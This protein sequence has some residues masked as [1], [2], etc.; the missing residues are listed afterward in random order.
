MRLL[1]LGKPG[2]GKGTQA[3][4]IARD[5]NI[6]AIST[7]DLIRAAIAEGSELGAKFKSYTEKGLLVPDDLVLAMVEERLAKPDCHRGFLLD[8][9]PRTVPQALALEEWLKE[10]NMPMFAAVNIVVP[11]DELV[12]RATGRRFCPNCGATYHIK[13]APPKVENVCDRCQHSPLELRADD[14]EEVIRARLVEYEE[15]TAPLVEFYR[16]RDL[17]VRIDG[18]GSPQEVERRIETVLQQCS[19]S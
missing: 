6:P 10:R 8:G 17:L 15:K 11:D 16:S 5:E 9:F 14:R 3:Q 18:V 13:F 19:D 4:R 12:L 2:S 1:L 7:G